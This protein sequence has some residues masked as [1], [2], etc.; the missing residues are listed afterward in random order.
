MSKRMSRRDFLKFTGAAGGILIVGGYVAAEVSDPDR[1]VLDRIQGNPL[2]GLPEDAGAWTYAN[3]EL[4]LDLARLPELDSLG[5]AVR[6][7]GDVLPDPVLV[8]LGENDNFYAFKNA[9]THGGRKIDPITGTMT[10]E[11]CSMSGSK[12]DY[13]GNV[14][15]GPAQAPLT[16]YPIA[17]EGST[18]RIA[19][20]EL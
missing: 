1:S 16:A 12:F 5:G 2:T 20:R 9:C 8:F 7:E 14:L 19:L 17:L 4:T 11:C 10:I 6:I 18:L 15:S 3:D 13:E